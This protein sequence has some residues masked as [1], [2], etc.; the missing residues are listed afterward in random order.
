MFAARTRPSATFGYLSIN[1]F[2]KKVC[3]YGAAQRAGNRAALWHSA[4]ATAGSRFPSTGEPVPELGG[5]RLCSGSE[6]PI[7]NRVTGI[8]VGTRERIYTSKT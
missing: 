5:D 6:L 4:E 2:L 1:E 3:W 7:A 8:T